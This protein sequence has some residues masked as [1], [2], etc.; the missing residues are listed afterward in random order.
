MDPKVKVRRRRRRTTPK[1]E[2]KG[3]VTEHKFRNNQE[4][5]VQLKKCSANNFNWYIP[6]DKNKGLKGIDWMENKAFEDEYKNKMAEL[7]YLQHL[8]EDFKKGHDNGKL[9]KLSAVKRGINGGKPVS[10][11]N[12]FM[13]CKSKYKFKDHSHR[14]ISRSR[15]RS[16][17]PYYHPLQPFI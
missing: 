3:M 9:N 4:G 6:N 12:S 8:K 15:Q 11:F 17:H 14:N 10:I 16:R 5:D 13:T 2:T 7:M 1:A